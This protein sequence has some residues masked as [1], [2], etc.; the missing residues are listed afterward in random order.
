[1]QYG[2]DASNK[3]VTTYFRK[4]FTIDN[5]TGLTDIAASMIYDDGAIVY[6]NGVEVFRGNMPAGQV[7]YSTYS[8]WNTPAENVYHGFV[9]PSSVLVEGTNVVAVEVHQL[10]GTSSDLSFDLEMKGSRLGEISD[11]T[12]DDIRLE[13]IAQSDIEFEAVFEEVPRITNLIINEIVASNNV[14]ADEHGD[15]DDFIEVYNPNDVA[16]DMAGLYISDRLSNKLKHKIGVGKDDE[17]VIPPYGYKILWADQ[18]IFQGP[19]HLNFKLSS[20]GE[21]IGLFQKVGETFYTLDQAVFGSVYQNKSMSR[22]PNATGDFVMTGSMT[23]GEEN[24]FEVPVATE[25]NPDDFVHVYP[26]PTSGRMIIEAEVPIQQVLIYNAQGMVL[27]QTSHID[28][29]SLED[30]PSGIYMMMIQF[31]DQRITKRIIKQ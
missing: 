24:I 28:N 25:K 5:L 9:I 13:D 17:T 2:P 31:D 7:G 10:N 12:S 19:L 27:V 23:P 29:V 22:I 20:S 3:Y 6:V 15:K 18:Q 4:T 26:N 21:E 30:F 16:V 8:L 14:Y 1:V 11:Y